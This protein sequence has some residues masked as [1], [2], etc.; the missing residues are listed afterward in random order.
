[1]ALKAKV[2][3]Y[4][5]NLI[6][7]RTKRK[8]LAFFVDDYGN[9]RIDSEEARRKM[10]EA[11]LRNAGRFDDYDALESRQDLEQLYEVL[12]SVRDLKGRHAVFTPLALPCNIDFETM[13][14]EDY[15]EFRKEELPVTFRKLEARHPESYKGAWEVWQ[16]GIREGFMAPQFH[17]REHLN[18]KVFNEKL[19]KRDPDLL[20]ALKN[21]SFTGISNTGYRT[22]SYTAVFDFWDLKENV[23]FAPILEDGLATFKRVYA[24]PSVHFNPPAGREHPMIHQTLYEHGIR[25]ID[26]PFIKHEHQGY[27]RYKRVMNYTGKKN[28]LGMVYLVRNAVF[29]PT[30]KAPFDWVSRTLAQVDAAFRLNRPAIIS[31]HRVNFCGHIDPANREKGLSALRKLLKEV[32]QRWPGVEFLSSSQLGTCIE[33]NGCEN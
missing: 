19:E 31:S 33:G 2:V 25:Y 10:A 30:E 24:C 3:P 15:R 18:L 11:G 17:G 20:T 8:I 13:A 5:K 9:V 14:S 21:R 26:T 6:G 12:S 7:W 1:M 4:L 22:I 23:A 27:G 28:A 29:E 32:V 16:E